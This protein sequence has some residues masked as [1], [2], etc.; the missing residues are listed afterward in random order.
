M[1]PRRFAV[2]VII[3]LLRCESHHPPPSQ[4]PLAAAEEMLGK[5]IDDTSGIKVMLKRSK[6]KK[7]SLGVNGDMALDVSLLS[8]LAFGILLDQRVQQ[9]LCA[10]LK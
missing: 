1:A 9:S 6:K 2:K 5:Q 3:L 8:A 4:V 7:R 10:C